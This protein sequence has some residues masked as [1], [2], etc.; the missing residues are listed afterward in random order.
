MVNMKNLIL[1]ATKINGKEF[2]FFLR[3]M[4]S[5][6]RLSVESLNGDT[7]RSKNQNS[8]ENMQNYGYLYAKQLR[9]INN[10]YLKYINICKNDLIKVDAIS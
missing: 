7:I 2:L 9:V 5:L 4:S 8:S 6:E 3:K 10:S 1:D